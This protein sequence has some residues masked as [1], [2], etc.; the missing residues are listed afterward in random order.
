M[1][2]LL[3][4]R[5]LDSVKSVYFVA[6]CGTGMTALAGMLKARGF[7][8]SGSDQ[9]VYPPMS[10]FLKENSI[11][12]HHG[13]DA[14]HLDPPPDLVVV[15]N[16]MSRGNAEVEAVLDRKLFYVSLPFALRE[17]F[18]RG[19]Y[20]CVVTGTHGKTTTSS[21]LAWLLESA[22]RDPSF[23]IGGI[24][25][26]FGK[27]FKLGD[28]K[29]FVL[30][31]DEYDTAFFD[32]ASKFLHY[33]PDL[34]I[35]NNIEFDHAD[36][37]KNLDEIRTAFARMVNLIPRN[38]F[39]L[40]CWDDPLVREV[41]AGA[42]AQVVSFGLDAEADW[43]A[44]NI[45]PGPDATEFDVLHKSAVFGHFSTA[46]YGKHMV[47]NCLA[48]IAASHILGLT[49]DEIRVGLGTFKNVQR[50]L[51]FKGEVAGV[52]IF[53]D[54]AHHPTE[55]LAT[56]EGLRDR[57]PEARLWAIFEPRTATSKRKIFEDKFVAALAAADRVILTPLYAQEKVPEAERLSLDQVCAGLK[58]K[59]VPNWVL[60]ANDEMLAFLKAN[61]AQG[62]VLLF[63]SNGDFNQIPDKLISQELTVEECK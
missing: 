28:G 20:S 22:G 32:K 21:L 30:E 50:R 31:G 55:V 54:F 18:I 16:V 61:V 7:E 47:R 27:G 43:R 13:F 5:N 39:L 15:G 62:D 17:F 25:E 48:V 23:F 59:D 52:K 63:M 56:T 6:I 10:T 49:S 8:V 41:S 29:H 44:E 51:Q 37:F 34:A 14:A 42:F 58:Q 46:L 40:S 11:P 57:F 35:I 19:K 26:N 33:L 38:G 36:I 1:T 60:P 9:N 24:P 2:T 53:D 45:Q 4:T 12:V 3:S